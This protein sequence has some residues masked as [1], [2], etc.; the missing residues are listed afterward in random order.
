MLPRGYSAMS[1]SILLVEDEPG[2]A[3]TITYALSTEGMDV[4][5]CATGEEALSV[6]EEQRVDLIILDIGLPDRNGFD[7]CRDIRN[8]CCYRREQL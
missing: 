6:L 5:W 1:R 8:I 3:D 7:L 2:I 4:A